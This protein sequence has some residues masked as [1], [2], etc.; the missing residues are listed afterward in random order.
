MAKIIWHGNKDWNTVWDGN[1]PWDKEIREK[2]IPSDAVGINRPDDIVKASIPYMIL[3]CVLCFLVVFA[4][5]RISPD[6]SFD[7]RFMILSYVIGFVAAMPLHEFLHAV[8]YPKGTTVYIGISIKQLRAFAASSAALTRERYILMSLAPAT[9]GILS[10]I[11]FLTAPVSAK[12][13]ITICLVPSFMGLLSPAPDYMDV[14]FL[15]RTV[16]A[17][18]MIQPTEDGLVWYR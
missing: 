8:C 14:I 13:L 6:F 16:P 10:L 1:Q 3:P 5:K 7:M 11:I 4:R 18:A 15:L 9:T 17:R 2:D 12:W